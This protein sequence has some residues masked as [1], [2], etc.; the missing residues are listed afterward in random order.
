MKPT[1]AEK[2]SE[3]MERLPIKS[4]DLIEKLIEAYTKPVICPGD[5]LDKIF[6]EAGE[7]SVIQFLI[8]LRDED[9]LSP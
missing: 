1:Y 4:L 6:F 3:P 8:N 2:G 7:W 5:S 9:D